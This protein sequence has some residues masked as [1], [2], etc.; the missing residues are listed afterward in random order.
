MKIEFDVLMDTPLALA[1]AI[2]ERENGKS[3][4]KDTMVIAK[5]NI[6]QTG[7]ALTNYVW[8]LDRLDR[9]F[10]KR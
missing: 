8:S 4:N 2:I 3:Y 7:Q 1:D 9:E 5:E 6:R 10:E